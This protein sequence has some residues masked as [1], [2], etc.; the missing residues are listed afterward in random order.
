MSDTPSSAFPELSELQAHLERISQEMIGLIRAY[1][2]DAT[3]PFDVLPVAREKITKPD[4]Y[5]R[6]LELSLEGRIYGEAAAA[7]MEA[8][9]AG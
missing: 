1:D 4:D 2:L 7:L 3:S 8:Q 5:V 6:F 9:K